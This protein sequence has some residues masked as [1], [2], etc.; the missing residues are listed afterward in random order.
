MPA[1][2]WQLAPSGLSQAGPRLRHGPAIRCLQRRRRRAVC[3]RA[4]AAARAR[5]CRTRDWAQARHRAARA[6]PR[7][8]GRRS[9]RVRHLDAAQPLQPDA[10]AWRRRSR[11]LLRPPRCRRDVGASES[12]DARRRVERRLHQPAGQSLPGRRASRLGAGRHLRR[13]H[14]RGGGPPGARRRLRAR[15]L[16]GAAPAGRANQLQRLR[17]VRARRV[18][19]PRVLFTRMARYADPRDML[20]HENVVDEIDE[21]RHEDLH[22]AAAAAMLWQGPRAT[23]ACCPTRPGAGA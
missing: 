10:S 23:C 13:Q 18:H 21:L 14:G 4:M 16:R 17:R 6:R 19:R 11:A 20:A 15:R 12:R 1:G 5:A 2:R 22:Q 7:G 3:R 8:R 9:Q